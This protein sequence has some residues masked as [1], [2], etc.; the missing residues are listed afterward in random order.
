LQ[1][2]VAK[3]ALRKAEGAFL[4]RNKTFAGQGIVRHDQMLK[5]A[6]EREEKPERRH[7]ELT[8]YKD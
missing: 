2:G 4:Y 7:V 6:R 3:L 1:K 5:E 8:Y